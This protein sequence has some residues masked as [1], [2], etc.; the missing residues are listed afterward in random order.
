M[1]FTTT[2]T[3]SIRQNYKFGRYEAGL[4]TLLAHLT[5]FSFTDLLTTSVALARNGLYEGNSVLVLI[6]NSLGMN[7]IGA[8]AL[9]KVA[10]IAGAV[11]LSFLGVRS[12]DKRMRKMIFAVVGAFAI[13]LVFVSLNNLYWIAT[14]A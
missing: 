7:L 10:F 4:V 2:D 5:V 8:I 9:T 13:L 1:T 11:F 12:N 14:T 3:T 6:A